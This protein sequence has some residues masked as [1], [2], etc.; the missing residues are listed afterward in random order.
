MR[1]VRVQIMRITDFEWQPG[2]VECSLID[3]NGREHLFEE[4]IPMVTEASLTPSSEFPQPGVIAC[5][6]VGQ[7]ID[8][9]GREIVEID[10]REPWATESTAGETRFQVTPD[11]LSD[12]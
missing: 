7:R 2:W 4:K 1:A 9:D 12:L 11:Q 10:T 8:A 6:V 3:A 5:L